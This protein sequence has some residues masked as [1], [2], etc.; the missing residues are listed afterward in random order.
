MPI[1]RIMYCSIRVGIVCLVLLAIYYIH[2]LKLWFASRLQSSLSIK[3]IVVTCIVSCALRWHI[4]FYNVN[5]QINQYVGHTKFFI[6]QE[7]EY[8]LLID[9]PVDLKVIDGKEYRSFSAILLGV[10]ATQGYG[11]RRAY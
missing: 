8:A 7:G 10:S 11:K 5:H 4:N 2:W 1:A 9:S 3:Y 6:S